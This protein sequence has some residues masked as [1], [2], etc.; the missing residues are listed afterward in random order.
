MR[1]RPDGD[2]DITASLDIYPITS[3]LSLISHGVFSL[4]GS[5]L[6]FLALGEV[7]F[8]YFHSKKTKKPTRLDETSRKG[9]RWELSGN[10]LASG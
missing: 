9:D 1:G 3:A 10:G 8:A 4:I 2:T 6:Y 5:L 7:V